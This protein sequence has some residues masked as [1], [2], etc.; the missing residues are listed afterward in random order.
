M[1]CE[2]PYATRAIFV[3]SGLMESEPEKKSLEEEFPWLRGSDEATPQYTA[4]HRNTDLVRK[5][6]QQLFD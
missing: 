5:T 3:L 2:L 1:E 4:I 6:L